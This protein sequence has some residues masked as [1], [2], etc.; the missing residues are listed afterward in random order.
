MTDAQLA[1]RKSPHQ[2]RVELLMDG[3]RKLGGLDPLPSRPT[4]PDA[5][6]IQAQAR[7]ILE[8]FM[9]AMEACGCE[10]YQYEADGRAL[11]TRKDLDVHVKPGAVINLPEVAK[12]LADLSVVTTGMFAEFGIADVPVLEEVDANN[13]AKFG[14]GCY[15]DERRKLHKPPNHPKPDI[16][17]IL[18]QQGWGPE[19]T[20]E[21]DNKVL[22]V[23]NR[24]D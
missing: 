7:I 8:E 22:P 17:S 1:R 18:M 15:L 5:K 14:P 3:Y 23:P 16:K 10:V 20:D 13:L 2:Q 21:A 9:E 6:M 24:G 12:E 4:V 11:V 19:T